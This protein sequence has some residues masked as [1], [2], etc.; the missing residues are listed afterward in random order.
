MNAMA[1][2]LEY[3]KEQIFE[4]DNRAC[5]IE[6]ERILNQLQTEMA[7]YNSTDRYALMLSALL[8]KVSTPV[9]ESDYFVGRVPEALPDE[10]MKAP[11]GILSS[12]GHMSLD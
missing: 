9:D 3:L 6:R 11:N 8:S 1:S 4:S 7:G 5:F 12:I 2:K 10:G